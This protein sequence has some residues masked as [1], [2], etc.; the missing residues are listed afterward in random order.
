MEYRDVQVRA[1]SARVGEKVG[2]SRGLGAESVSCH[3]ILKEWT[4]EVVTQDIL[5]RNECSED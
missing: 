2:N 3:F 4:G 5:H 1:I